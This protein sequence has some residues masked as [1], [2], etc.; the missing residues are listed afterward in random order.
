MIELFYFVIMA[1]YSSNVF[2]SFY[3]TFGTFDI[4]M[5]EGHL[6]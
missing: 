2:L 1:T 3:N 5:L 4:T 6:I